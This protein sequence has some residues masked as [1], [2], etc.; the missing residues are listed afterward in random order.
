MPVEFQKQ[1]ADNSLVAVWRIT[2]TEDELTDI[3]PFNKEMEYMLTKLTCPNRK[4]QWLASRALLYQIGSCV[5]HVQYTKTGQPYVSQSERS[6]SISHTKGF[7]S[8]AISSKVTAGVDIEY[9]SERISRLSFKYLHSS[10]ELFIEENKSSIYHALIWCAKET[11]FKMSA[12]PGIIFK[13]DIKVLPFTPEPEGD[14]SVMF[15]SKNQVNK[16]R[17]LYKVTNDYYLVWHY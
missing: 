11:I 3:I 5:P 6:I 4:L 2:E 1:N 14:F 12:R 16:H 8:V 13:E 9:P 15:D 17:L 10:E 7:A